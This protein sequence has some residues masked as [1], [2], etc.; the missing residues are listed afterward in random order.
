M[1]SIPY[2]EQHFKTL[3]EAYAQGVSIVQ[4]GDKR[5]EY[6]S[7]EEMRGILLEMADALNKK[8]PHRRRQ[9]SFTKGLK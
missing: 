8:R 2:T 3:S 4:Y 5:I 6:R 7:K 9:M 1:N